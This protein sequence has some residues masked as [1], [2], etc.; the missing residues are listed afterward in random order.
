MW[1]DHISNTQGRKEEKNK[2]TKE[3]TKLSYVMLAGA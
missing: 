2:R 1:H 3:R